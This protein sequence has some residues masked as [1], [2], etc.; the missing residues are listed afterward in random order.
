MK[1]SFDLRVLLLLLAVSVFASAVCSVEDGDCED[2]DLHNRKATRDEELKCSNN[3]KPIKAKENDICPMY[4]T[5]TCCT[6]QSDLDQVHSH[7]AAMTSGCL[8]QSSCLETIRNIECAVCSPKSGSFYKNDVLQVCSAYAQQAYDTCKPATMK[9]QEGDKCSKGE[10]LFD[11]ARSFIAAFGAAVSDSSCFDGTY[12]EPDNSD[13]VVVIVSILVILVIIFF[14]GLILFA[15]HTHSKKNKGK[16]QAVP[17]PSSPAP[18]QQPYPGQPMQQSYPGQPMQQPYPGQPMH[19]SYPGEQPYPGQPYP[20]Q[21]MQQSQPMPMAMPASSTG[22]AKAKSASSNPSSTSSLCHT[23]DSEPAGPKCVHVT[24][25]GKDTPLKLIQKIG[26]GTFAAVWKAQA[27][28]GTTYALKIIKSKK[29]QAISDAQKEAM[30]MMLLDKKYVV[31]VCGCSFG[32]ENLAIAMEYFELGSLQNI[33]EDYVM[34][35]EVGI[36]FI[37]HIARAMEYLHSVNIIHRD[38][39]PGN[40]LVCSLDVD[41]E[42]MC[43]ISDFGEARGVVNDE[44]QNRMTNGVGTPFYM[45]PEMVISSRHY[46]SAIDVY[47]FSIVACQVMSGQLNYDPNVPFSTPYEFVT[48]M[49]KGLRPMLGKMPEEVKTLI[50]Q[51]WDADAEKRPNFSQVVQRLNSIRHTQ[52]K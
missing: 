24:I 42:I 4:D 43:K 20:G 17:I 49:T 30:M 32:G 44:Q 31:P 37:H 38:L 46:T 9:K 13:T 29:K 10:N 52:L 2:A 19:Q 15:I 47:S 34:T 1:L 3:L 51:C 26:K 12:G 41:A 33:L 48:L 36:V 28:D 18:S 6:T 21:P 23:V 22:T 14:V 27:D 5:K 50:T 40:V 25:A 11:S 16:H 7:I 39:K 8:T 35:P 45:A